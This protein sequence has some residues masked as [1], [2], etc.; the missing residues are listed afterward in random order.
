MNEGNRISRRGVLAWL[1]GLGVVALIPGC[2]G[3]GKSGAATGGTTTAAASGPAPSCVLMAELTKGPYYL[4][5]DLVRSDI[6]EDRTGAPLDLRVTVVDA[7]SCEPLKDAAVDVWHCDAEGAYSGVEG[8]EGTFLRGIQM[9]D[10][11]GLAEFATIYPGWYTGRAVHVHVKVHVGTSEVHTGQL[12]F[13]DEVTAS[14]YAQAPYS[15]R[16]GPDRLNADDDIFAQ[17][18]GTT[19]VAVTSEGDGY[20]GAVTL[21]V[22]RD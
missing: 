9:T 15:A 2:G 5:L 19:I 11:S 3:N 4:D 22:Q 20:A 16:S 14:V 12:F 17:S 8:G 13:A 18:G 7:T 10:A 6:T 1:G 21:G